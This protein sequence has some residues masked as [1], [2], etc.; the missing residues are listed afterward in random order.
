MSRQTATKG[1]VRRTV[2]FD[3]GPEEMVWD[4]NSKRLEPDLAAIDLIMLSHWHR[5]HSGGMLHAV[6]SI[7]QARQQAHRVGPVTVDLHPNRPDF[8]GF[9]TPEFVIS[10]EP[11]P[12]FQEITDSGAVVAKNDT[13]HTVL[14]DMFLISGEIPRTTAYELGVRRG[15]RFDKEKGAWEEDTLIRDERFM[16]CNLKGALANI[17]IEVQC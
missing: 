7:N 6:K 5:D 8:R 12:T 4:L 9:Q 10:L 16:M 11:D 13:M 15:L 3:T 2:L 17:T 14:D 1:D